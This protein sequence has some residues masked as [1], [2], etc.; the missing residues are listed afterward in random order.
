[1]ANQIVNGAPM[2]IEY[3][4]QDLSTRQV[5]RVQEA[6]PQHLPKFYLFTQ[7]GPKAPQLVSG[8]ERDRVFGSSSFDYRGKYANHQTV[9]ANLANAQGNACMIQRLFPTDAGPRSN[10]IAW[11]DVLPTTVD[12]Y[13]RNTIDGSIKLDTLNQPIVIGSTPGY[14]VK[15]VFT[16]RST[17]ADQVNFGAATITPGD[18]IDA[19]AGTQSTRYPIFEKEVSSEGAWGNNVGIRMWAPTIKS[20]SAMPTK[21]MVAEKAYPYYISVVERPDEL[22]S[23]VVQPTLFGE[24]RLMVTLKDGVVDPLTDSSLSLDQIFINSYQSV[25]DPRYPKIYGSFGKLRVYKTNIDALLTMFH[26]AEVPFIDGF[27]DIGINADTK[28][29]FNIVSGVSSMNVKYHSFTFIDDSTSSRL[30]EV[31][32]IYAKGG[33]DGTMTFESHAELTS[34]EVK[35]YLDVNDELMDQAYHVERNL[36]DSGFPMQ[37][38][39]DLVSIIA[40]RK[41]TFVILGTHT[42][43]GQPLS[44]SEEQSN[45]IALRTHLQMYP[46]SDY[47]GTPVA[48][49]MIVGCSGV[50]RNS[51]Y[52]D[53]LPLTGEVLI[54]SAKYMGSADRK[55]KNGAHFDGAPGSII[56]NFT[57]VNMT[58]VPA[59]VRN[60]FWDVGL[61]WVLKYD[62]SSY[63][64]PAMKTV[65]DNDTSVLNNYLT[66]MA[67]CELNRVANNVWRQFSGVSHLTNV[68]LAARVNA[69]V[70]S[71]TLGKFDGRF[72]IQPDATFTDMDEIRGFSLTLPIKLYAPSM[73]TVMTTYVQVHRIGDLGTV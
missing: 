20:V 21:M 57:D 43:D 18:Q 49:G 61:N 12:L 26:A 54:K 32:N 58:W 72:V 66:A 45:A 62:R 25:T 4:V 69:A 33:S 29:L 22:S 19:L 51:Q 60:R 50:L 31:T 59:S 42:A 39:K 44:P 55:W 38:K 9:F 73:K 1:M 7:K 2:V 40:N 15:W 24:Q 71:Q 17:V 63:F 30:S 36:Y 16:N 52:V 56:E 70:T 41:D 27:S 11:L 67:C 35:R 8:A 48:R 65:Y 23:A 28:H 14:K 13:D 10:I 53:R 5:P 47:F 46:E 3:G 68:Q 37:T 34:A 6:I 64:F